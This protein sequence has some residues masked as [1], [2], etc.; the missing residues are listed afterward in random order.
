MA[1][2]KELNCA[3]V[4]F[5]GSGPSTPPNFETLTIVLANSASPLASYRSF[6]ALG[7]RFRPWAIPEFHECNVTYARHVRL[8]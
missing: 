3:C 7:V 6:V 5:E 1:M 8:Q 2:S 4:S